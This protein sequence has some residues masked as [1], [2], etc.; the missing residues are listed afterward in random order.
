MKKSV[1]RLLAFV[2]LAVLLSSCTA[3]PDATEPTRHYSTDPEVSSTEL[4]RVRF[5]QDIAI[6]TVPHGEDYVI[7]WQDHALEQLIR[8]ALEKPEGDI[9]HSDVWDI[10]SV[11]ITGDSDELRCGIS[12]QRPDGNYAWDSDVAYTTAALEGDL[13]VNHLADLRHFDSLQQLSFSNAFPS[14]L[15]PCVLD[16]TGLKAL[17]SLKVLKLTKIELCNFQELS[18]C[19]ALEVLE[20]TC[21]VESLEPIGQLAALR[22]LTVDSPGHDLDLAPL[23]G[24]ENL[25]CLRMMLTGIGSLEPLTT[26][27]Q[28]RCLD[29]TNC[30]V[31]SFEPLSRTGITHLKM[32]LS[33]DQ[34]YGK[35]MDYTPFAGMEKLVYLDLS[36]HKHL[37]LEDCRMILEN[38]LELKYLDVSY[39][40]FSNKITYGDAELDTSRLVYFRS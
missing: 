3:A 17:S 38:D 1:Q 25:V 16:L 28:L 14:D 37:T 10:W 34:N 36:N 19:A 22:Y 33:L 29:L 32:G 18:A 24:M 8:T 4:N 27:P 35:G 20:L 13:W 11:W 15:H 9:M 2:L 39:C 5:F 6:E 23:T 40:S 7:E 12:T 31:E 26:M 21:E 30:P